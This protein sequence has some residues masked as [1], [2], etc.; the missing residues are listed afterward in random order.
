MA[1]LLRCQ[2]HGI[3]ATPRTIP[4]LELR[5]P[6]Q[7]VGPPVKGEQD[8]LD[9][10]APPLSSIQFGSAGF[11][12]RISPCIVPNCFA[13][14]LNVEYIPGSQFGYAQRLVGSETVL[15]WSW[16]RCPLAQLCFIE[17]N[18]RNPFGEGN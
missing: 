8:L 9:F 16:S 14:S 18:T 11:F 10:D 3:S 7:E 6:Y 2:I 5:Y 12:F 1:H 13:F 17:Y 4:A 15:E